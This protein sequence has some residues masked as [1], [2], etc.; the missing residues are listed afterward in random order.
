MLDGKTKMKKKN[1]GCGKV[2]PWYGIL[3]LFFLELL[4]NKELAQ[5]VW[6]IPYS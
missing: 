3:S 6:G 2:W 5:F 1:G 4:W